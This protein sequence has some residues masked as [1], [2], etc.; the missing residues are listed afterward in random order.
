M[1]G[2]FAN[3]GIENVWFVVEDIYIFSSRSLKHYHVNCLLSNTDHWLPCWLELCVIFRYFG[4]AKD[5][6]GV[7]ELFQQERKYHNG[8]SA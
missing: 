4:A 8:L 6:P 3:W 5:L 1:K 2:R 7:R